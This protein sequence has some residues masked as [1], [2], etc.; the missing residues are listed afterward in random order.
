MEHTA[1]VAREN[2]VVV[3]KRSGDSKRFWIYTDPNEFIVGKMYLP[4]DEYPLPPQELQLE[5][6]A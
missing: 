5:I 1:A 3:L 6:P 4:K 2:T